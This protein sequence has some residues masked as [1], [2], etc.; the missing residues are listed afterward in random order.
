MTRLPLLAALIA[1]TA[2]ALAA[3]TFTAKLQT[4]LAEPERFVAD[5]A[6]WLCEGDT[7]V[8]DLK[9]KNVR[10]KFC[11]NVAE[12]VGPIVEFSNKNG[13]LADADLASCN[14]EAKKV[15]IPVAEFVENTN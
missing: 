8:A 6:V 10:V 1:L 5:S 2:P 3:T 14:V 9:R 4:P 15:E 7:C 11:K 12:E 13:A